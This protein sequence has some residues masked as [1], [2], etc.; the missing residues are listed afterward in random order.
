[1]WIRRWR[2][3]KR[4]TCVS[5]HIEVTINI[6]RS[7]QGVTRTADIKGVILTRNNPLELTETEVEED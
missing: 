5:S 2:L 6:S 3:Y 7:K 4:D 1:M